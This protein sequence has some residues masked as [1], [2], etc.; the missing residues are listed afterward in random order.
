MRLPPCA[1]VAK[2]FEMSRRRDTL[3]FGHHQAVASLSNEA[4]FRLLEYAA[5]K[6]L[7]YPTMGYFALRFKPNSPI[8][9]RSTPQRMNIGANFANGL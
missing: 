2:R 3:S 8:W 1:Y 7:S 9:W 4:A 6:D 5:E